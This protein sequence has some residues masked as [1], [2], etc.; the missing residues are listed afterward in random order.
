MDKPGVIC[1]C[2]Y[3]N[4]NSGVVEFACVFWLDLYP[5]IHSGKTKSKAGGF[6][7]VYKDRSMSACLGAGGLIRGAHS[8]RNHSS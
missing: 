7:W 2:K 5:Q 8:N 1:K 6:V 4:A 3:A